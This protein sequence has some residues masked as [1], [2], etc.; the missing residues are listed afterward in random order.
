MKRH[1][2]IDFYITCMELFQNKFLPSHRNGNEVSPERPA[3]TRA[4]IHLVQSVPATGKMGSMQ[5]LFFSHS[6]R[7]HNEKPANVRRNRFSYIL[8]NILHPFLIQILT[9]VCAYIYI[10]IY[11]YIYPHTKKNKYHKMCFIQHK[12]LVG[13]RLYHIP[14]NRWDDNIKTINR[15]LG[16]EDVN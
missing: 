4:M 1:K 10:Y 13:M 6:K 3:M 8:I 11:I 9:N 16:C 12:I 14:R 7:S 2:I 15:E 5:F